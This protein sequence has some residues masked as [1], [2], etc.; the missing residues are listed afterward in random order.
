[1]RELAIVQQL[2]TTRLNRALKPLGLT[3]THTSLLFHLLSCPDGASIGEIADA[4]EVNQPAVSKTV[5]GLAERGILTV[6]TAPGDARR[7]TVRLTGQGHA[8]LGQAMAAMHPDA[9]HVFA[10]LDDADLAS[11]TGLLARLRTHLD[12]TRA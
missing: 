4:M 6:E 9:T 7:R 5:G 8:L 3:M 12:A 2:A 11:L 10:P 1:M